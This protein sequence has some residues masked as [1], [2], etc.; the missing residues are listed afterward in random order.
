MTRTIDTQSFSFL[1]I[2]NQKFERSEK[3]LPKFAHPITSLQADGNCE[4]IR[5]DY[6][7]IA[8]EEGS[9]CRYDSFRF[10]LGG[11][12]TPR[13][14]SCYGEGCWSEFDY[15]DDYFYGDSDAD[16]IGPETLRVDSNTFTFYFQSDGSVANGHVI[17]DWECV[18]FSTTTTTSTTTSTTTPR[19]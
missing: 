14:C 7:S 15:E 13:R 6:N 11:T 5:I 18:R 2:L 1:A 8:V 12:L 16:S 4:E 9:N 10:D 19:K 3:K 17:V